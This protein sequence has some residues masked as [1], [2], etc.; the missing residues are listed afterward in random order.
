[1]DENRQELYMV[2]IVS[3]SVVTLILGL[4]GL[5]VLGDDLGHKLAE[6]EYNNCLQHTVAGHIKDQCGEAP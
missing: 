2:I 6:I 1:M 4:I 5:M 3:F